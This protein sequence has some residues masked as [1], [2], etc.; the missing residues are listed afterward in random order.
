[1]AEVETKSILTT[2]KLMLGIQPE[3][4]YFDDQLIGQA[5]D[6]QG[7]VVDPAL[8]DADLIG[9]IGALYADLSRLGHN[10]VA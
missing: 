8:I 2:T 3:A 10:G 1:M 7:A 6:G 4:S 9:A 5:Y